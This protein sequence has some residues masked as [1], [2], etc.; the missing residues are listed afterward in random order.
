MQKNKDYEEFIKIANSAVSNITD[1]ELK[2]VAFETILDDLIGINTI[3]NDS[4]NKVTNTTNHSSSVIENKDENNYSRLANA[5]GVSDTD[6]S[7]I[8]HLDGNIDIVCDFGRN[9]AKKSQI[10]YV[11]L[12]LYASYFVSGDKKI[13]T[14]TI[15]SGMKLYGFGAL[16]NIN[17]YLNSL[18][19]CMVYITTGKSTKNTYELTAI[20]EKVTKELCLEI[21]KNRGVFNQNTEL[22]NTQ[23]KTRSVRSKL[24]GAIL[25]LISDGFFNEP[26]SIN[27]L[28]DKLTE[29]G[30]H[31]AREIIDEKIRRRFLDK[32]L[33]RIKQDNVWHYTVK[34]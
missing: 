1:I 29:I 16:P 2:K 13:Q 11:L 7:C 34:E 10:A 21:I 18:K 3:S 20:G 12:F 14:K 9:L 28:K 22:L 23:I 32:G 4:L 24:T 5:L 17:A 26:T 30:M 33:R 19:P 15:Q 25:N 6:V 8:Y 31:Y 27:E